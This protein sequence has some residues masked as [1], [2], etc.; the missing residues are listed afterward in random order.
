M[1]REQQV[2]RYID[3]ALGIHESAE[4]AANYLAVW[5]ANTAASSA[6]DHVQA[7]LVEAYRRVRAM[8]DK[9]AT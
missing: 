8:A 2:Q 5:I 6:T 4:D 9:E 1:K 3:K 7:P